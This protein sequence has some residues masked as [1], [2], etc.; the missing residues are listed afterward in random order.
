MHNTRARLDLQE[1]EEEEKKSYIFIVSITRKKICK[2]FYID[3]R[4]LSN[5]KRDEGQL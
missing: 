4:F 2:N 3:C 5:P 1:E